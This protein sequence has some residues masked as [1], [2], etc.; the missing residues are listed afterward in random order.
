MPI[1]PEHLEYFTALI[2]GADDV[3]GWHRW[4]AAHQG[5]LAD[6]PRMQFLK[7]KFEKVRRA[8]EILDEHGIRYSW[9]PRGRLAAAYADLDP[10]VLDERGR[11]LPEIRRQAYGGAIG[12][13]E[14]GEH[15]EATRLLAREIRRIRKL[16]EVEQGQELAD[17]EFDGEQYLLEGDIPSGRAIL[18][19][20][21]SWG[22]GNDLTDPAVSAARERLAELE[23]AT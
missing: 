15:Q 9:S 10:S 1:K 20:V 4:W 8:A 3:P 18:E 7:L 5:E 11:P 14:D 12:A 19:A 2:E 22:P 17:M 23:D 6:L 13:I 16:D 21:A